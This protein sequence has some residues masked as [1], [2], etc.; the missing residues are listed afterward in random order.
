[1]TRFKMQKISKTK[2]FKKILSKF[3]RIKNQY[4][5]KKFKKNQF[6]SFKKL[7]IL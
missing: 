2:K 6:L 3:N 5:N 7:I 1:M 4:C